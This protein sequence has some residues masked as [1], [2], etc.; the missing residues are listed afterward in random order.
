MNIE[1]ERHNYSSHKGFCG[2]VGAAM[3][4]K[5]PARRLGPANDYLSR[6][7]KLGQRAA[8]PCGNLG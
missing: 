1:K 2:I 8:T 3:K 7:Y 6:V 4:T 5:A